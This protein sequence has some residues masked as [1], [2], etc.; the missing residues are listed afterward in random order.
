MR[1]EAEAL[2]KI[3]TNIKA[4][5]FATAAK[6]NEKQRPSSPKASKAKTPL[7]SSKQH[8]DKT[9]QPTTSS[10]PFS[11]AITDA[12]NSPL[13]AALETLN[14]SRKP[15]R[16]SITSI[17]TDTAP[18]TL[19]S[20]TTFSFKAPPLTASTTFS[21][22]ASNSPNLMP[23]STFAPKLPE[24]SAFTFSLGGN[25][26]VKNPFEE[27]HARLIA[28][29]KLHQ[30]VSHAKRIYDAVD[31]D[32][33]RINQFEES[34][35]PGNKSVGPIAEHQIDKAAFI[36]RYQKTGITAVDLNQFNQAETELKDLVRQAIKHKVSRESLNRGISGLQFFQKLHDVQAE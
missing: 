26:G 21:T 12:P 22:Q 32:E 23:T 5:A 17:E 2:E 20:S 8:E 3:K 30:A 9:P 27:E 33:E 18:P 16:Y 35:F 1:E 10:S 4:G 19:S 7:K 14:L 24:S 28:K 15:R 6:A 11:G 13:I 31:Y 36:K 25:A 34:I 29:G